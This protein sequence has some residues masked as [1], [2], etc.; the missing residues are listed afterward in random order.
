M[1]PIC[2][3]AAAFGSLAGGTADQLTTGGWLDPTSESA[4][5]S[6]R[7]EAD[8]GGGRSA[9]IAL[10]ESTTPGADATSAEFQAAIQTISRCDVPTMN[11]NIG[12]SNAWAIRRNEL[13]EGSDAPRSN[14]ATVRTLPSNAIDRTI[15]APLLALKLRLRSN[16]YS[17]F[18]HFAVPAPHACP[19]EGQLVVRRQLPGAA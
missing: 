13:I 16:R 12:T 6:D 5:V 8:Y 1:N 14:M 4:Q 9:F 17:R 2:V 10:F 18:D 11:W 19:L 3:A 15:A 7:L